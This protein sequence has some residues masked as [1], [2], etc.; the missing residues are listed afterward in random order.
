MSAAVSVPG[1]LAG[2]VASGI[3][4][5]RAKDLALIF[6][7]GGASAAG[8]FTTN[9]VVAAP[10]V[11]ARRRLAGGKARAVLANA[12]CANACTGGPGARDARAIT[13]QAAKLLGVRDSDVL[14]ASTGVIGERIPVPAVARAMPGLVQELRPGG[15]GDAARAIMTTDTRPKLAWRRERV[16]GGD[17]RLLGIAKGVGMIEPH[18][19]TL[20]VFLA[21]NAR[22][23]APLL[24]RLLHR[25]CDESF[26]RLTVDGCMSTN[27][28]AIILASGE[29]CDKAVAAGSAAARRFSRMLGEVCGDLAEQL[30]GDGEGATKRVVVRVRGARSGREAQAAAYAAGNSLLVKTAIHG[31]DPNWGRIV[32]ALGAS[33]ANL[34]PERISIRFGDVVLLR[35]GKYAGR[36]SEARARRVMRR[37]RYEITVD[38]GVGR[39]RGEVLTC[40][41]SAGYVRINASYRS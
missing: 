40:D 9:K 15:F 10:V 6:C 30:A 34:S 7:P 5:G 36:A 16:S 14:P 20:L 21:T 19:A 35:R 8:V 29:G 28:T 17:V 32:Q 27:D 37:P 31:E 18:M 26:N 24:G 1:F 25:A 41:L 11:I 22:L 3:K 38:L 33:P 12:G 13:G 23:G 4:K 39:G 2:G